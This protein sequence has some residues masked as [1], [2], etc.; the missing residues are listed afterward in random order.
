MVRITSKESE[1]ESRWDLNRYLYSK[2]QKERCFYR[3]FAKMLLF[4]GKH[5]FIMKG[6]PYEKDIKNDPDN[7]SASF[8]CMR[9]I[10][11]SKCKKLLLPGT[12]LH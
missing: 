10:V 1:T 5:Y 7:L 4:T 9:S 6:E 12:D 11:V 3:G 2:K 8:G